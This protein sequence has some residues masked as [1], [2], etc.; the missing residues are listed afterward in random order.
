MSVLPKVIK[1]QPAL[2]PAKPAWN[3]CNG[4]QEPGESFSH[5]CADAQ[6]HNDHTT[7]LRDNIPAFYFPSFIIT[8]LTS[9]LTSIHRSVRHGGSGKISSV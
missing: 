2:Q 4:I 8:L 6:D 1:A 5:S 7:G 9:L 3:N